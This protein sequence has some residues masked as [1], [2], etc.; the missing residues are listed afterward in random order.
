MFADR[1]DEKLVNQQ[2]QNG[3]RRNGNQHGQ[4]GIQTCS[5]GQRINAVGGDHIEG[6]VGDVDNAGHAE[7]EG[8]PDSQ[9]GQHA[10]R[11]QTGNE[12]I[13]NA[14]GNALDVDW[15]RW[16]RRAAGQQK[17]NGRPP[18]P[19]HDDYFFSQGGSFIGTIPL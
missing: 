15:R 18:H 3:H 14:S 4:Q 2:S 10:A 16:M 8:K 13:H 9:Q 7:D 6:R 5:D 1:I 11:D 17:R 12:D 19:C